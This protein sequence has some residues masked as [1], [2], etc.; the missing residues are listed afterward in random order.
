MTSF[1]AISSSMPASDKLLKYLIR[2]IPCLSLIL[3]RHFIALLLLYLIIS[4][5]VTL[6]SASERDDHKHS[7]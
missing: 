7:Y 3:A 5:C 1:K 2:V 4:V 6:S